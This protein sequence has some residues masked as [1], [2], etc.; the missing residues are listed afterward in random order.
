MIEKEI[1]EASLDGILMDR[2]GWSVTPHLVDL[3]ILSILCVKNSIG[4]SSYH[5][6]HIHMTYVWA[7]VTLLKALL[8]ISPTEN[9]KGSSNARP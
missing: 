4:V 8:C 9:L 7:H 5:H 1:E 3:D 2:E 6:P